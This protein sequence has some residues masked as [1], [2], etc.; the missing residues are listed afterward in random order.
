MTREEWQIIREHDK[1]YDGVLWIAS[2]K[3]GFV[4]RPSCVKRSNDAK[5]L[6]VFR[7][8]E[9]AAADGFR[10]CPYCHPEQPDLKNAGTALVQAAKEFIEE[11]YS[12]KF[13]LEKMA[14]ALFVNGNHLARVFKNGTGYTLL[15]YHYYIRCETAKRL[16]ADPSLSVAWIAE[17]VG[18]A[19]PSHFS[20]IFRKYVGCSP[21]EYRESQYQ[22]SCLK[23]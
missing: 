17:Q 7:S 6:I 23:D 14:L 8:F 19:S 20:R 3:T 5:K 1:R 18:D 4:C 13:S 16:L 15:W 21:S 22:D 11:H 2:K 9:S 10:P 12:D